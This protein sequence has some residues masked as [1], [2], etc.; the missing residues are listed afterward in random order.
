MKSVPINTCPLP[1]IQN[2]DGTIAHI[3]C[4]GS[5][6]HVLFY[7][8]KGRHCSHPKCEINKQIENWIKINDTC[9]CGFKLE[10]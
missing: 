5:Y 10:A 9:L 6:E 8:T 1:V 7:D 2:D 4:E 3:I